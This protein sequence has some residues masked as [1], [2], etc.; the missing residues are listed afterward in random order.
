MN[1][2]TT[3]SRERRRFCWSRRRHIFHDPRCRWA[4]RIAARNLES[5]PAG[6]ASRDRRG[7][8][9]CEPDA[10]MQSAAALDPARTCESWQQDGQ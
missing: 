5:G 2:D 4:H 1:G 9:V 8:R 7:C 10:D 3:Q 6:E